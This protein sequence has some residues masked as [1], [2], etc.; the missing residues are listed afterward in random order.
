MFTLTAGYTSGATT[1]VVSRSGRCLDQAEGHP[2]QH[3]D[4]RGAAGHGATQPGRSRSSRRSVRSRTLPGRPATSCCSSA[5][6]SSRARRSPT[7]STRS[8]C[9]ASTTR[10]SSAQAGASLA[11]RPPSSFTADVSLRRRRPARRSS[12]SASW[13]TPGSSARGTSTRPA[14]APQG[15]C[16]WADR[17]HHRQQADGRRRADL[18]LPRPVPRDRAG[19][20][21][22]AT[23]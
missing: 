2:P 6:P 20:G 7:R 9:W 15:T 14:P 22:V 4:G 23:R 1:V 3:D 17:V 19:E 8:A 16:R 11:P 5:R 10:R 12:T 18:R 13:S 21:V